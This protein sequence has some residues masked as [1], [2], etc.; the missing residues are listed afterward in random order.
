MVTIL[1]S[2]INNTSLKKNKLFLYFIYAQIFIKSSLQVI[3]LI[4]AWQVYVLTKQAFDLGILG[5]LQFLP[6]LFL[7]LISGWIVDKYNKKS[8]LIYTLSLPIIISF[9]LILANLNYI[10]LNKGLIFI[11]TVLAG[12]ANTFCMPALKAILPDLVEENDLPE[13][14]AFSTSTSQIAILVAPVVAGFLYT[15]GA[16]ISYLFII[17]LAILGI[18][19][20]SFLPTLIN[21][22]QNKSIN[23]QYMLDGVQYIINNKIIFGAI[24]LDLFVVLLGGATALLPI[25]ANEILHTSAFGL[26]ILKAAPALGA[27][28]TAYILAIYQIQ[29]KVGKTMFLATLVFGVATIGFSLSTHFM[30]SVFLLIILGAADVFSVIIRTLLIQIYTPADKRGRVNAVNLLFI[31]AS[32]Q[33]GQFESGVTANYFGTKIATY[34]GGI[35]TIAVV[36]LWVKLFPTLLKTDHYKQ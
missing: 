26:G 18:L 19:Y 32:N 13:A 30:L 33:L 28:I 15:Y 7:V 16:S 9:I 12:I 27:L 34:I 25:F 5:L 17:I 21:Y 22:N 8:I 10:P 20:I 1:K 4:F 11:A 6:Q 36:L 35:G 2:I 3:F 29:Y 23:I 31:G 24:S 14:V